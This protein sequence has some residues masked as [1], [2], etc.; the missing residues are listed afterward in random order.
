MTS[1]KDLQIQFEQRFDGAYRFFDKSGE[2]VS[3]LREEF[4]FMLL[5]VNLTGCEMESPDLSLRLHISSD[6]LLVVSTEPEKQNE[7]VQVADFASK[8]AVQL[9][10][11]FVVEYNQLSLSSLEHTPSLQASF[12]RSI[13]LL[14]T[15]IQDLSKELDLPPLNQDFMFSFESGT[16]AYMFVCSQRYA[17][18]AS[19]SDG[20][21]LWE[22]QRLRV[23]IFSE[24]KKS[25]LDSRISRLTVFPW[26][27]QLSKV[28]L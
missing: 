9:F 1:F 27:F 23:S 20:F 24:R 18:L 25:S 12:S 4:G 14:P 16:C 22:F 11:P 2:F 5:N 15:T 7:L 3:T 28:S 10:L 26:I 21:Q 17:V 13:E 19:R 8:T 6:H